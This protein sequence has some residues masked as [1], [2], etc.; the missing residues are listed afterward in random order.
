MRP[1]L[2]EPGS[3]PPKAA[4]PP[5]SPAQAKPEPVRAKELAA[6]IT[7]RFPEVKVDYVKERRLKVSA[8]P[9]A[10]KD[11]ALFARDQLGFDHISAVSGVDWIAK[12]EFEVVYFVGSVSRP[13]YGDFVIALSER[14]PRNGPSV[15]TLIDVWPGADYHERETHEMF[16]ITFQGHPSGAHLLLPE[17]WNDLPPLRKDY[18]SPGR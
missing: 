8:A 1:G 9:S 14:T 10:I 11:L 18:N 3:P 5:P 2:S 13:G 7:Q 15:P 4:P 6:A 17:D 12:G 16:G